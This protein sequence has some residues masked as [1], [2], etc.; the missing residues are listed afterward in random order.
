MQTVVD[1]MAD[2]GFD[3]KLK[4]IDNGRL[5]FVGLHAAIKDGAVEHGVP[6][7]PAVKRTIGKLGVNAQPGGRNAE[8]LATVDAMR[9]LSI[10]EMFAGKIPAISEIFLNC[11][12]KNARKVNVELEAKNLEA[13]NHCCQSLTKDTAI[14]SSD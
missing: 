3:A 9:F 14:L 4:I 10:G 6:I 1:N 13:K 11:A 12:K 8:Q 7:I 5:E 2:L